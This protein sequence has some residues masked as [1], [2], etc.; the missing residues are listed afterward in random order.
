MKGYIIHMQAYL[1]AED[2][3]EA[4]LAFNSGDYIIDDFYIEEVKQ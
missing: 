3:D 1:E 2:K 4:R